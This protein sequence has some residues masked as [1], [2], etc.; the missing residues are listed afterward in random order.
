MLVKAILCGGFAVLLLALSV[1][2]GLVYW[3]H[4]DLHAACAEASAQF[5]G[6]DVEALLALLTSENHNLREK[7]RAIWALGHLVDKRALPNLEA[8]WTGRDCDHQRQ[9]CQYELKKAL[10]KVRGETLSICF[11]H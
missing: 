10:D 5:P 7:N 8:L 4:T 9:I 11:W 2:A 1:F 3:V 6:D